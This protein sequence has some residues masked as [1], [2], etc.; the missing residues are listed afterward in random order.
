MSG[1]TAEQ[2]RA[3]MRGRY[4]AA[5]AQASLACARCGAPFNPGGYRHARYCSGACRTV[6]AAENARL[7]RHERRLAICRHCSQDFTATRA[8][9]RYCSGA[10]RQAA[11]RNRRVTDNESEIISLLR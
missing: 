9:G 8:D 3:E 11:Y 10:C 2:R 4:L 5:Q 1:S 6:T 7:L